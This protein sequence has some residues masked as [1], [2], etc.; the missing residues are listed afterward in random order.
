M[1]VPL[2]DDHDTFLLGLF[3][4]MDRFIFPNLFLASTSTDKL[5][6]VAI[7]YPL[8]ASEIVCQTPLPLD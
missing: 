4:C 6:R 5:P 2:V 3:E 7:F 1:M 8:N